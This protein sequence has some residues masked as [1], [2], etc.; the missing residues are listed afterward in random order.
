M[1][2]KCEQIIEHQIYKY[3]AKDGTLGNY[4]SLVPSVW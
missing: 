3:K 4:E 2:K 1:W